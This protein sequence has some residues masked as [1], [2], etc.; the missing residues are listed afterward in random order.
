MPNRM[1]AKPSRIMPMIV[2]TLMIANQNSNSPNTPT[3]IKLTPKST[4]NATSAGTHCGSPGTQ[5]CT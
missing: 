1:I 2:T 3:A 5:Y 4:T